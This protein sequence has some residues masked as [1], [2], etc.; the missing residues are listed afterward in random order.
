MRR[1]IFSGNS[2]LRTQSVSTLNM[3][4]QLGSTTPSTEEFNV[5][6]SMSF[7]VHLAMNHAIEFVGGGFRV[8]SGET[9]GPSGALGY[10]LGGSGQFE[11]AKGVASMS[12]AYPSQTD[13]LDFTAYVS[14]VADV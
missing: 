4:V 13:P 14:V 12:F 2:L 5:T 10:I 11:G 6:G 3:T 9:Q 8:H 7:G 1:F